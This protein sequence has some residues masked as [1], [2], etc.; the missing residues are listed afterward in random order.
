MR[1]E[2]VVGMEEERIEYVSGCCRWI[3]LVHYSVGQQ[4]NSTNISMN[5]YLPTV[6]D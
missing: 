2:R 6:Y 4:N 3:L 5:T 1:R